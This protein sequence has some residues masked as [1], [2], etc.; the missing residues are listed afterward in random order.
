MHVGV[1]YQVLM[2]P[3]VG[4]TGGVGK[5]DGCAMFWRSSML[6]KRSES[7]VSYDDVARA[8]VHT[9]CRTFRSPLLA[10]H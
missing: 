8:Q 9:A 1:V 7:V 4:G 3:T 10:E 2:L 6:V 5:M